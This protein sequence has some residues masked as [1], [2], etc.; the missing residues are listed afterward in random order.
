MKQNLAIN[1]G[2]K[3]IDKDFAWP[4]F[5][6]GISE[7]EEM[8]KLQQIIRPT[9]GIF[10]NIGEAHSENFINRLQKAGEKLKLFSRVETLIYCSDHAEIQ[11]IIIK[12]EI[13][14]SIG[15]FTWS[16]K[17]PA[18]LFITEV[19]KKWQENYQNRRHFQRK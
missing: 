14:G 16:R 7:P 18:D 8:A 6:A 13:L 10:T 17:Q 9:I 19:K 3:T 15:S 12:S 11:E 5:E 2:P 1:G 4:I